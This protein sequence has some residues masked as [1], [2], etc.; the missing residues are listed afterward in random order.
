V[1]IA[2]K[3]LLKQN[4]LNLLLSALGAG[5]LVWIFFRELWRH[6]AYQFYPIALVAAAV[7]AYRAAGDLGGIAVP[8]SRGKAR[9][10]GGVAGAFFIAA[11]TLWSPWLAMLALLLMLM[12][13]LW[14]IGGAR[15]LRAFLPAL[16][17]LACIIPP[18]LGW[19]QKLTVWLAS[20]AASVSSCALDYMKVVHTLEGNTILLPGRSLLVAEA[21]SGINSV[22][23]CSA[24]CLFYALWRRRP[25][26]WL[27]LLMPLTCFFVILGNVVRITTGAG[28]FYFQHVNW[29]EGR[30]HEV[31]GLVLL[32]LYFVLIASLDQFMVFLVNPLRPSMLDSRGEPEFSKP[33]ARHWTSGKGG[34][35]VALVGI[36]VFAARIS[37]GDVHAG[38]LVPDLGKPLDLK[39]SL[40]P[41]IAGWRQEKA[42]PDI[43]VAETMGVRSIVWR[44][45]RDGAEAL[46]A[47]DYP[48]E[49]FH[50][51]KSCYQNSGWQVLSEVKMPAEPGEPAIPALK[52]TMLRHACEH[53]VVYHAVINERG[54]WLLP[55]V[56]KSALGVRVK[57]TDAVMFQTSYRIQ[58]LSSAYA[59]PPVTVVASLHDLFL[60]SALLLRQQLTTQITRARGT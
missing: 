47:V 5:P 27:L 53:A 15:A 37:V 41:E 26:G 59:E 24:I 7:L 39:L 52:D 25:L 4:R 20:V 45:V 6:P 8:G 10:L 30:S 33:D 19:D 40:P 57:G 48:L 11:N 58:A 9:F 31:F 3:N 16:L 18:P 13:S 36:G 46:V 22:V 56:R 50:N 12:T 44:F 43:K 23:L 60:R 55:P 29:L 17:V 42:S 51:V 34:W 54:E 32:A 35:F 21:C 1:T 38:T 49:G 14:N 2:L 28:L